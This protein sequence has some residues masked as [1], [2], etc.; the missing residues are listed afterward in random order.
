MEEKNK[1]WQDLDKLIKSVSKQERIMLRADLNGHVGKVNIRYEGIM[2]RCGA[3]TRNE[4]G[5]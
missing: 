3:G 2:G 1:I 5:G 4:E